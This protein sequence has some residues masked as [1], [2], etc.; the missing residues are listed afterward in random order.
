MFLMSPEGRK[1]VE[2]I[3]CTSGLPY[4]VFFVFVFSPGDLGGEH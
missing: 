2:C 1:N 4:D 3:N